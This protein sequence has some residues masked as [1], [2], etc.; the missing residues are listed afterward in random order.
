[1]RPRLYVVVISAAA[2]CGGVDEVIPPTVFDAPPIDAAEVDAPADA[3]TDA[4]SDGRPALPDMVLVESLMT[5]TVVVQDVNFSANSCEMQEGCVGGAGARRLLR[6]TTVTA[7]L[8]NGDL[9]FGPPEGNPLFEFSACHGH[10][11]FGGYADYELV[12]AGGVVI[13]GHKQAFCLLDTIQVTSGAPGPYY[14]CENQGISAGW[15]DQYLRSLPCQWIDIT[16][17]PPGQYTLR[18]RV[19]PTMR[20]EEEDY[21]NNSLEIPVTF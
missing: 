1:M 5:G 3:R 16:D 21:S 15:A 7:N 13:A 9:Y 12:N 10:Y 14:T 19:N 4:P 20:F 11:H 2:A 17:V 18:V 8:G 6:F